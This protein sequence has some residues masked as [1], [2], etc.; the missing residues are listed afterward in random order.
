MYGATYN[1]YRDV[2]AGK[3]RSTR[4]AAHNNCVPL[5]LAPVVTRYRDAGFFRSASV[6]VQY[7]GDLPCVERITI[8]RESPEN[9]AQLV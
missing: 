6:T 4:L 8:R 1:T 5:C 3:C 9:V 2:G 7:N